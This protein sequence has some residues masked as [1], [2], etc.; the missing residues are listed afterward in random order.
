MDTELL[1]LFGIYGGTLLFSFV[2]GF[3]PIFNSELFLVAI[4]LKFPDSHLWLLAVMSAL[5]QM[6]AKLL[7][8]YAGGGLLKMSLKKYAEKLDKWG[9]KFNRS[10]PSMSLLMFCS[11]SVGLPPFYVTSIVAGSLRIHVIKFFVIGF[12]GRFVRFFLLCYFPAMFVDT[13]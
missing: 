10:E 12:V 4:V 6:I 8:Y 13:D 2:S 11:A 1:A 9:E 5:G 3:I 7:L